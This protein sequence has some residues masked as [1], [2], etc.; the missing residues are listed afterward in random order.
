MRDIRFI[1]RIKPDRLSCSQNL[2][3]V[4]FLIPAR[5]LFQFFPAS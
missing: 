4:Y 2:A 5:M 3:P 1:W